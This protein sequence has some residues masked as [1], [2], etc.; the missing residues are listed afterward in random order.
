M[1]LVTPLAL[2]AAPRS[3]TVALVGRAGSDT[4]AVVRLVAEAG[5]SILNVGGRPDIVI[6]RSDNAGFVGR[7]YAAGARLVL[8]GGLAGGCGRADRTTVVT[9]DA[10]PDFGRSAR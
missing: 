1:A 8:D 4:G 10:H 5:G 6:A 7:L 2:L 3:D 9:R